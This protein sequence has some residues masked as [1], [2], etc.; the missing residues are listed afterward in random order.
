M[1]LNNLAIRS[2]T[3]FFFATII[4]SSCF[5]PIFWQ[6]CLYCL[7]M[8]LGLREF[9]SFFK[10]D[11]T[12]QIDSVSAYFLQILIYTIISCTYFFEINTNLLWVLIPIIFT[13][14]LNELWRNVGQPLLNISALLF[15]VGYTLVPFLLII[16]LGNLSEQ[17]FMNFPLVLGMYLMIWTN[18]TFAY[19]SGSFFGKH[20]LFPRISPKKTWEGTIGGVLIT[21]L[22]SLILTWST[23]ELSITF[24]LVSA[25]IIAPAAILGDLLESLFKRVANVKDSGIL[26]PGHGGVLDRFDAVI[27]TVPFYYFWSWFYLEYIVL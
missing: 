19:L 14:L 16:R 20:P 24:W 5:A 25:L 6:I 21:I 17:Q 26:F 13:V 1:P 27:F 8:V 22:V 15:G 3:G 4:I 7:L 2:I 11:S 23:G 18:D 10:K 12:I 9:I